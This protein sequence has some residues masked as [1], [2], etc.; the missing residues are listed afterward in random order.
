MNNTTPFN[1]KVI[2]GSTRNGRFSDKA[3][4]WI[5]EELKKQE[6]VV[7]EVLDLLDYDMPFFNEAVSPSYK[8]E[9]YKNEAVAR[10]TKKIA[11]G[12]AFVMVTPEYNHSTSGVLKNALD[13][14]SQ[15]WNNKPVAFVAYGSVG[16]ARAV[17]HLRLIAI[18][19]QMAPIREAIHI[20]GEKYF[21]VIMGKANPA[22]LFATY[23]DGAIKMITQL[24]W[25]AR[26]LKQAREITS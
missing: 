24:I 11:E 7:V 10:F 18:E 5:S 26:A 6:G 13:W 9:P 4:A 22:D 17:E 23:T 21:P 20:N 19:L 12:D 16:G 14:V 15:E 3:A 25:W 2:T 1:I 8:T